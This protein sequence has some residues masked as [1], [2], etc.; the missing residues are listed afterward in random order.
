MCVM[1]LIKLPAIHLLAIPAGEC[2]PGT[3]V[4]G[5][6]PRVLYTVCRECDTNYFIIFARSPGQTEEDRTHVWDDDGASLSMADIPN[7]GVP[8]PQVK[9]KKKRWFCGAKNH[10]WLLIDGIDQRTYAV[11]ACQAA[12]K[13]IILAGE[14]IRQCFS[15]WSF[16]LQRVLWI[17]GWTALRP[18]CSF[19]YHFTHFSGHF[20]SRRS[21]FEH[22]TFRDM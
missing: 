13:T 7:C 22:N 3:V 18:C 14:E 21:S 11:I 2:E 12:I 6:L 5:A 9:Q 17:F 1:D 15:K 10:K 8:K 20:W 4:S 16:G 19:K